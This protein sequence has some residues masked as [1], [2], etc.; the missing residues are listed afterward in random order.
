MRVGRDDSLQVKIS[1]SSCS[2]RMHL[3][4]ALVITRA[5]ECELDDIVLVSLTARVC[6]VLTVEVNLGHKV[7]I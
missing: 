4:H 3:V 6:M 2:V 1:C 7:L 5:I